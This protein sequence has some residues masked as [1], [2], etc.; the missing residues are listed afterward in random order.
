[1]E[2]KSFE[3][4]NEEEMIQFGSQLSQKLKAGDIVLLY[5]ELGAGK[6]TL[7]RGVMRGYGWTEPV[8]SPTFNLFSMYET[9]P[10]VLHADFYRIKSTLG[11]GVEDYLDTHLCLI[12]WP[13]A[14]EPEI[15]LNQAIIVRISHK[16][17]GRIVE[18]SNIKV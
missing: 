18:V 16:N 13:A 17:S 1:M 14:I 10:P 15:E 11:L 3:I 6:T 7:V 8:R 4:D 5:G 9:T 12:E 2:G